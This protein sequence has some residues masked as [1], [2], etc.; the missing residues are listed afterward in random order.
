MR[1]TPSAEIEGA[2]FTSVLI[3]RTRPATK[4]MEAVSV[5]GK[6]NESRAKEELR[7]AEWWAR[8]SEPLYFLFDSA[9]LRIQRAKE[10]E[11]D[12][13]KRWKNVT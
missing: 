5:F 13:P 11:V 9:P 2:L 6:E 7:G 1:V 8:L 4:P 12:V 3:V 10:E